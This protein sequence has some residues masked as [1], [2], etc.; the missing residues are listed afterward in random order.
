MSDPVTKVEIEDVL[1]SIRRLVTEDIRTRQQTQSA[2]AEGRLMLTPALRVAESAPEPRPEPA[3]RPA[4]LRLHTPVAVPDSAP[5]DAAPEH[6]PESP[7]DQPD[8]ARKLAEIESA[9]ARRSLASETGAEAPASEEEGPAAF[10]RHASAPAPDAPVAAADSLLEADPTE[11]AEEGPLS[12]GSAEA[13]RADAPPLDL[14]QLDEQALRALVTEIVRQEL[15][16]A[17]GERITRNVRKLVRRE[18]QRVMT[19]Q[20]V[21]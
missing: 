7:A 11:G 3:S 17:L 16:G 19:T 12:L 4:P 20:D 18:I 5:A 2:P 9:L 10:I 13:V 1:S 6:Q 15:Q 8:M 21:D 14:S